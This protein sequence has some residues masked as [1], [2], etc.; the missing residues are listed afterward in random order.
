M[1]DYLEEKDNVTYIAVV[2]TN[3]N[4][5]KKLHIETNFF[6]G[7]QSTLSIRTEYHYDL[8][9]YK[10]VI[11]DVLLPSEENN[12]TIHD[13]CR[14]CLK[15]CYYNCIYHGIIKKGRDGTETEYRLI[16][17]IFFVLRILSLKFSSFDRCRSR[18]V[19]WME[20]NDSGEKV[21]TYTYDAWGN[22]TATPVSSIGTNIYAQYNPFATKAIGFGSGFYSQSAPFQD[23]L[24]LM[25]LDGSLKGLPSSAAGEF[26]NRFRNARE[27]LSMP[28]S[29]MG[30]ILF[31][32]VLPQ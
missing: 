21:C 6:N 5:G 10:E 7:Q 19:R 8:I 2:I 14:F 28:T 31:H 18:G 13:V 1:L 22:C 23:S 16:W 32:T 26:I 24:E 29:K 12:V 4:N 9:T 17:C 3:K 20:W 27:F 25:K 11:T 30:Y 15:D